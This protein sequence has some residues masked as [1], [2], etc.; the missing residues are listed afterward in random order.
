MIQSI[1][2]K[3]CFAL[4][5]MIGITMLSPAASNE[6]TA[7]FIDVEGGQS[8]L[9]VSPRPER[10]GGYRLGRFQLPRCRP[11]LAAAEEVA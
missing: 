5:I 4:L 9:F 2:M 8:D 11:I 1:T 10:S 7:Y 6:L 3:L